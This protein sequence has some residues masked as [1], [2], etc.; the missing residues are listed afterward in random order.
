MK[1]L[2]V[3]TIS[4][5]MNSFFKPHIQMLV[6]EGNQV[7]IACNYSELALDELYTT[8]G[9]KE[10]QIDFSRSPL[11]F[12]NVKAY[13]QLDKVIGKGGYDIVHCHTPNASVIT[14]LVCKKFRK[15][16]GLKVFYTAHGFHFYK[17]APM[18]NWVLYYP[19]EKFCSR[20]TDKLITINQEDYTVAKNKFRAR[21]V[22]YV[23][24]VGIDLSRFE[25]ITVDRVEKRKEIGVSED[26]ILLLSVGELNKNK[27]HQVIIQAMAKLKNPIIQYV[28]AGVGDKIDYLVE[29]SQELSLDKQVHFLGYRKDVPELNYVA[30]IFCF[31]SLREG[32]GLS[33]IEAMAC[34]LP[35]LTSNI[36]GINDYS[37]NGKSG[38]KYSP[39][40]V[41][42]FAKG[43]DLFATEVLA[44]RKMKLNDLDNN[45]LYYSMSNY[46]LK[47]V[48]DY[49]QEKILK[50][51]NLIYDLP[52]KTYQPKVSIVIPAYNAS[53]Y[54]TEAIDSALA[55]TYSNVEIIVVNDGSTDEGATRKIALSYGDK[56]R[57]FEKQNGGSSSAINM[58]IAHMTGEW[59]SWLS[60]DDLYLPDKIEKQISYM[61]LLKIDECELAKHVFFSSF[62]PIDAN[63]NTIRSIRMNWSREFADRMEKLP[64]NGYL[65]AE[66][67]TYTFHGCSCLIHKNAFDDIGLFDEK[68]RWLNDV[69]L[70]FRL[71]ANNYKV[72]FIPDILVKG[73]VHGAQVSK[74]IGYSYHNSEQD[75]YW[76][77]SLEWLIANYPKEDEL[78][79]L[80]GRNAYL[81][82]RY[83][84]GDDAFK[85]IKTSFMKKTI[86]KTLYKCRAVTKHWAKTIYAKIYM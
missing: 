66:P 54:L 19:I 43:I 5:T 2:Y 42:G 6:D 83:E 50:K 25:G 48:Y 78:F 15:Q 53:N 36:H 79:F 84:E 51:M 44:Y 45:S 47:K 80:F 82:T 77:R 1:I 16:N 65:I 85:H 22:C 46:N 71:F 29:M 4:L 61:T 23:P 59:F 13:R 56:I 81:K 72:H 10:Y 27:N 69:D 63:G 60:H 52:S 7:D 57:Y 26:A 49:S 74:S 30:D 67:T 35:L 55:Q 18:L 24:G 34:G 11:S 12:D 39:N 31:P 38:F 14:R 9:C 20:Y 70:W 40:D 68:L 8:L 73:R 64:H 37:V 21:E 76:S 3:T 41:N 75:M 17:G 33:A 86:F 32:L 62:E 58:G 28:I